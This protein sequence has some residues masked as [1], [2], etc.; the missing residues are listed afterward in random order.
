MRIA[1]VFSQT[2]VSIFI[3]QMHVNEYAL[4]CIKSFMSVYIKVLCEKQAIAVTQT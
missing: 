1:D 4:L 3:E 2:A